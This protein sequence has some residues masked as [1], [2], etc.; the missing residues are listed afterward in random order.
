MTIIQDFLCKTTK[1]PDDFLEIILLMSF[2]LLP[3]STFLNN[4]MLFFW[5]ILM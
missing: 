1:V 4:E 2:D 3:F 5:K